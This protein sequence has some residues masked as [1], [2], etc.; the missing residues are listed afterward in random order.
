MTTAILQQ[1]APTAIGNNRFSVLPVVVALFLFF[2]A[3]P[4]AA[5]V[6]ITG[7]TMGTT[8]Q[9]RIA[10]G[11]ATDAEALR[12]AI[13]ARLGAIN[14]S[15]STY[16][17]DSE[18]SRFNRSAKSG[19]PVAI[20]ADFLAVMRTAR[21]LYELTDG[22][23][24]GTVE[25]LIDLWGIY[26]RPEHR[27]PPP[28]AA[29]AELMPDIGF[30]QITILPD[31]HLVKRNARVRL[32]LASV[33]KG[34]GVDAVS[35]LL[36]RRGLT[37]HIVEIGGE[38]YASGRKAD[39]SRWRIGI[40]D[41]TEGA[42][43][44]A[45]YAVIEVENG[46]VATSGGY[47]NF[48]RSGGRLYSHIIDPRNGYPVEHRVVSASVLAGSCM[49]ADG[50]ATAMMVMGPEKGLAL[51]DRIDGIECLMIVADAHGRRTD[52]FSSGF[53]RP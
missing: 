5:E 20:S 19:R 31:G 45:V 24:D 36:R 1:D 25:P 41:P 18:L 30:D 16:I 51:T 13:A 39:G 48:F 50:L 49:I 17:A 40:N 23:W 10:A 7:E 21:R 14:R 35:E 47:R 22:A 46:A 3:G 52:L 29:I 28:A 42:P 6:T 9:V 38:V 53:P 12:E 32:D 43:K 15:M 2:S 8:Y 34:F 26:R 11:P 37:D 4:A 44:D 27:S 33:A